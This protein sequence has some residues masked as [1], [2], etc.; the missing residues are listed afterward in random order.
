M[1][2]ILSLLVTLTLSLLVT[3][4][5]A[6]ALMLTGMSR[7]AAQFQARSAFSGVGYTT[8]EAESV[9]DHPVRRRI[10]MVLML[11]GNIGVA[12]VVATMIIS[13]VEV[14]Q[15]ERGLIQLGF[16][17]LG[18]VGLLIASKSRWVERRLNKLIA[19]SLGK[20]TALEVR[21]YVALL[22]LREGYAVSEMK[23]GKTDWLVDKSLIELNLPKEGILVLGIHRAQE[24]SYLGAPTAK[25]VIHTDDN[26][27]LYGPIEQVKNLYQRRAGRKGDAAH[28]EAVNEFEEI[29]AEREED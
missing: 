22:S 21:D 5:A 25:T 12:T 15:N 3:R 29:I 24:K 7:E 19:W 23:V 17:G 20:F 14:K 4:V 10:V 28:R 2:A 1:I 13:F 9:V 26:L 27:I 6:M 11:L 18:L 8:G 16:L